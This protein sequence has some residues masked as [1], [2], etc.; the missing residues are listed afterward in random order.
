LSNILIL[1]EDHSVDDLQFLNN[2][3]FNTHKISK[4]WI[5]LN[6]YSHTEFKFF[7]WYFYDIS[8][9]ELPC[10]D[11]YA[12]LTNIN[13]L[14]FFLIISNKNV[15]LKF[16]AMNSEQQTLLTLTLGI[17]SK[18]MKQDKKV[19]KKSYKTF[20]AFSNFIKKVVLNLIK[21]QKYICIIK[22][23]NRRIFQFVNFFNFSFNK[24]NM[25][26]FILK[27]LYS[28]NKSIFKKIKSIK[29][30][31]SQKNT[32]RVSKIYKSLKFAQLINLN[33]I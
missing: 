11:H 24:S 6:K 22:G 27:P 12:N 2:L 31:F 4:N 20:V 23:L 1:S 33:Y 19:L 14:N 21:K 18:Y 32:I 28:F 16:T 25:G 17:I 30:K 7:H 13:N 10:R 5:V 9:V 15:K 29:R 8:G 26:L 3:F